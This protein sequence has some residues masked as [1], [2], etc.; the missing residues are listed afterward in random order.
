MKHQTI[1]KR[2]SRKFDRG[3][4]LGK[5]LQQHLAQCPECKRFWEDM[6]VLESSIRKLQHV[7]APGDLTASVLAATK[8]AE[9]SRR[10][11]LRPVWAAAFA[12]I[13]ALVGGVWYGSKLD[14]YQLSENQ[15]TIAEAFSGNAPGSLWNFET[16]QNNSQ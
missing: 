2:L 7:T 3:Q 6:T 14:T 12:I 1:Q 11:V 16:N 13:L 8:R 9:T 5:R 15:Q 10:L 4:P